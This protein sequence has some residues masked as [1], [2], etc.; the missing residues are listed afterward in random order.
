MAT[1]LYVF[2]DYTFYVFKPVHMCAISNRMQCDNFIFFVWHKSNKAC[3]ALLQ[4]NV[5]EDNWKTN[6]NLK[7]VLL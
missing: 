4:G 5:D 3:K 2:Q 1:K 6:Y 7:P